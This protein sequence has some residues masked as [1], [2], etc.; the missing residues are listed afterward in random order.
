MNQSGNAP[1]QAPQKATRQACTI[2]SVDPS[3]GEV[4]GPNTERRAVRALWAR[5]CIPSGHSVREQGK[6]HGRASSASDA[7][8][9]NKTA[10]DAAGRS[11]SAACTPGCT[12]DRAMTIRPAARAVFH[13]ALAGLGQPPGSGGGHRRAGAPQIDGTADGYRPGALVLLCG[14]PAAGGARRGRTRF[15]R[16]KRW[17]AAPPRATTWTCGACSPPSTWS[18]TRVHSLAGA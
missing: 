11:P 12:R 3:S 9:A 2:S 5:V 1:P 13:V 16:V 6:H 7:P 18:A 17:S 8:E 4:A 14:E 15:R 10:D